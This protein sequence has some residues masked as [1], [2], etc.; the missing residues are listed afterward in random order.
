MGLF[1]RQGELDSSQAPPVE[2][3]DVP[4]G[5]DR[6]TFAA[7]CVWGVEDAVRQ[8]SGGV[9]VLSGYT[10]GAVRAPTYGAVCRGDTGHAEAVL[11]TFD[12]VVVRYEDLLEVFWQIHDPTTIDRQGPDVGSQYRSAVFVRNQEQ[13][14]V[15]ERSIAAVQPRFRRP[16]VTRV[17]RAD[18]FW[19]AE[20]YHQRYTERTGR[21][22]CHI[23]N[24]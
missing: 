10:G 24:W 4:S 2:P 8:V 7:G 12:P 14:L 19:P 1:G 16:I 9:D 13:R 6:A 17:E 22:G 23:A 21:G 11:V 3:D 5:H 15:A 20:G 18:T